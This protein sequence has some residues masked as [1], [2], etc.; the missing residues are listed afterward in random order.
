MASTVGIGG[1][2]KKVSDMSKLACADLL[3]L[4]TGQVRILAEQV[5][6]VQISRGKTDMGDRGVSKTPLAILLIPRWAEYDV[7]QGSR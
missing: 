3:K 2:C 7:N 5:P 1:N 6:N 4:Q